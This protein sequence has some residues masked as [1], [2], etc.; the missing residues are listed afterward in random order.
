MKCV[1][2]LSLVISCITAASISEIIEPI[3]N[4]VNLEEGNH[5]QGDV[6]MSEQQLNYMRSL[7]KL[8]KSGLLNSRYRWIKNSL[9]QV[10]IP[11]YFEPSSPYSKQ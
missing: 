8:P 1:L 6:V 10:K 11:Y 7:K 3:Q 4:E 5:F 2:I 9:G